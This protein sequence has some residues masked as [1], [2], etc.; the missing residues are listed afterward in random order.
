[1][2]V[3]FLLVISGLWIFGL[4]GIQ[5]LWQTSNPGFYEMYNWYSHY[6]LGGFYLFQTIIVFLVKF[7]CTVIL[8]SWPGAFL[9]D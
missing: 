4:Y 6:G 5:A 9:S 3:I 1:M 7:F 2:R 8:L